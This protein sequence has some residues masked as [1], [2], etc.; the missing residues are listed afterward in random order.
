MGVG[1]FLSVATPA[2]PRGAK[3]FFGGRFWAVK[4]YWKSAGEKA[5]SG[6]RGA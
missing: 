3:H 4:T 2:E 5:L 1:A 6:V